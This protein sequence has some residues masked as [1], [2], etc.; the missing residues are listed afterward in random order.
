MFLIRLA[1][2]ALLLSILLG[3]RFPVWVAGNPL[4]A[5]A[6]AFVAFAF[7]GWLNDKG[8]QKPANP[9]P[10]LALVTVG[11][12]FGLLIILPLMGVAAGRYSMTVLYAWI[13]VL[14]PVGILSL[15]QA[16][17]LRGWTGQGVAFCAILGHGLYGLGQML[18]R[19]GIMPVTFWQPM[20]DWDRESQGALNEAYQIAGRSTGLFLNANHFG[21]WS[22]S[23]VIYSTVVLRGP[24][25]VVGLA[26]GALGVMG[27]QSRTAWA[28]LAVLVIVGAIWMSRDRIAGGTVVVWGVFGGIF[29]GIASLL[30]NPSQLL[31]EDL[32][33]RLQSG[34]G[35]TSDANFAARI[36]VWEQAIDF[37]REYP[38]GT[39]G[40]PQALFGASVD[41]Q[42]VSLYMQ[43][44]ALLVA[45]FLLALAAPIAMKRRGVP[46][47]GVMA[48]ASV[49]MV[50]SSLT[51]LP[52]DSPIPAALL[53][54]LAAYALS[55]PVVNGE[56][57]ATHQKVSA[58]RGVRKR[59]DRASR[60]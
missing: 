25:R 22:V 2:A 7:L 55:R 43:G 50:V 35:G 26:L 54:M 13:V 3:Q 10:G 37:T 19:L 40:P 15:V 20:A 12:L 28:A 42:F 49:V 5:F 41:N 23:A 18:F 14:V 57:P 48:S 56:D 27:S 9:W 17:R 39:W 33:V 59:S 51:M 34:A 29:F 8:F 21:L 60:A 6:L 31:E 11:P 44:G 30:G 32:V 16:G 53:W 58:S 36:E 38:L 4:D 52:L 24:R 45:A 1:S 46:H 47:A